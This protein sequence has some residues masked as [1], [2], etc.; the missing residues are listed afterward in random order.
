MK[1]KAHV[2]MIATD[3]PSHIYFKNR[4]NE[5]GW[6]SGAY[7]SDLEQFPNQ[8]GTQNQH[9]YITLP[10]SNL[11]I[12][13][14]KEGDW[15]CDLVYNRIVQA[16][17]ITNSFVALDVSEGLSHSNISNLEKIIASTEKALFY[18]VSNG[19][20]NPNDTTQILLPTPSQ[21]FINH[22]I[23]EYNKGNIIEQVD[24]ELEEE[25]HNNPTGKCNDVRLINNEI[26]I[27]LLDVIFYTEEEVKELFIKRNKDL[28][29]SN[30][31]FNSL[32]LKQDLEWFEQHKKK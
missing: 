18:I 6:V 13:K 32:L 8:T 1:T 3:K 12:S 9:L 4:I 16:I 24:V 21:S 30:E 26:S 25:V 17:N 31:K 20:P 10:Q 22:Y 5:L 14:I 2:H 27:I 19:E 28:S 15:C 7:P 11:E 23:T 29:T